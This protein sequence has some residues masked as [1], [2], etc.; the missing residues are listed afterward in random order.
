MFSSMPPAP[1]PPQNIAEKNALLAWISGV[2]LVYG[3]WK[4][5]KRLYK[6]VETAFVNGAA[7]GAANGERDSE[8]FAALIARLDLAPLGQEKIK[9]E[10]PPIVRGGF[11]AIEIQNNY[12][13]AIQN[14][15]NLVVFDLSA[16][17]EPR[18][19]FRWA[20]PVEANV[21]GSRLWIDGNRLIYGNAQLLRVFDLQNPRAPRWVFECAPG[22]ANALGVVG[23]LIFASDYQN[24]RVLNLPKAGENALSE[25][26]GVAV[27]YAYNLA[28][29]TGLVAVS[30]YGNRAYKISFFDVS[31]PN[32]PLQVS[33]IN[34]QNP[35]GW[36]FWGDILVRIDGENLIFTDCS[37]PKN[38][39]EISK[40]KVQGARKF[41]IAGERIFV[42]CQIWNSD[43]NYRTEYKLRILD[44]SQTHSPRLI[45]EFETPVSEMTSRDNLL[46]IAA[47][48]GI[49]ILDVA[50]S[51]RPQPVGQKPSDA[52]FGYL[53]RR[54]R[55][56][57][58]VLAEADGSAFI[59][60]SKAV[61]EA[62]G[63]GRDALDLKAQW[64]SSELVIGGGARWHQSSHGR[65]AY[66][67]DPQ[68]INI[69]VRE[70]R[71]PQLWD[72][73]LESARALWSHP[74]L[75][76]QTSE[77]ARK[78]LLGNRQ[79]VSAPTSAQLGRFLWA[80]SPAF[81][82]FAAREA[83]NRLGEL[84]ARA[85]APLLWIQNAARRR[86]TLAFIEANSG[87]KTEIATHLATLLGQNARDG[88]SRRGRGIALILAARFDLSDQNFSSDGAFPIIPA[89]I[90]SAEAPLRA[91]G[92][93]FCR[94]LSAP[95]TLDALNWLL[96]IP[97]NQR[98][99]FI[100]SLCE[101]ASRGALEQEKIDK[102][103]RHAQSEVRDAAWRLIAASQ[104]PNEILRAVWTKLFG[105]LRRES[106]YSG[107]RYR[108]QYLGEEWRESTP[109]QSA[110][111]SDAALSVLGRCEL[112]SSE[113]LPR[114]GAHCYTGNERNRISPAMWGAFSL[115]LP[116]SQ[117]VEVVVL[118][119]EWTAWRDAWVRA[120][121]PQKIKLAAFWNAVQEFLSGD[122]PEDQKQILRSR[123]FEQSAVAATFGGAAS[124]L[125]PALLM[126]LI[127]AVPDFLWNTW[128]PSL[129]ETLQNDAATREAF[130]SAAR[131][132]PSLEGGFLRAR[133]LEDAEF[134]ATF[135]LLE[136]DALSA[137]NPAFTPLLLAWLRARETTLDRAGWLEAATHP[138]PAV[139]DLGL[140]HLEIIGLDVPGAL[141]LLE[142]RLPPSIAFAQ[143][144]FENRGE[145]L[146]E[147][148]LALSD[149]PQPSVRAFGREFIAA[150]LE[151]LLA[152]GLIGYLQDNPNAE[153][154]SFVAA[155]L[156][157]KPE[158]AAPEF[159]RA[160]LR[161][162]FRARRAKNLIQERRTQSAPLPDDK[163]L[164]EIARGRT[165]CDAEWALSQLARRA[166][167]GAQIEGIEVG[168]TVGI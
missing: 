62:A 20:P 6:E 85:L 119:P 55:R 134:A 130:W 112:P 53:K 46:Y 71:A 33:Q 39:R 91:L 100:E 77:M 76:W 133:L 115:I 153:M 161:S 38:P 75:P 63:Q 144:W 155:Q 98:E 152:N 10:F 99:N 89:L 14:G 140:A 31:N 128:R 90:A 96:Q 126:A 82:N 147:L 8:I 107:D 139:R 154:Q 34:A 87:F 104:T 131:L 27:Q 24:L 79:V 116:A 23:D 28:A 122:K 109:L 32:A 17:L 40:I 121:A 54:A 160:V 74:H 56:F 18:E 58:R 136:T 162:R 148:A 16:P 163:T 150:R 60:L 19:I 67:K 3:P 102:I 78:I 158:L 35:N 48:G 51:A 86:E 135:G 129:L 84:D 43:G 114:F 167:D 159:D 168:E 36:R 146:L 132:S 42:A 25:A 103:V 65:G 68:K 95:R 52:T 57:L 88:L 37:N 44:I 106:I 66:I 5:F 113:V 72:A 105:G 41:H 143:K 2:S 94:R 45:G 73:H 69:K 120:N 149:S 118:T 124:Q 157:E 50:D 93:G 4:N 101:S 111:N 138:L 12:L 30:H 156:L 108:S 29:K 13:Y 97:L 1:F 26:G 127:G 7:N 137:D 151:N 61:L 125:S 21:Y 117:V 164:L 80:D 165:P 9:G 145:K 81:L 70:E 123:T 64:V 49:R 110:I 15:D 166:L 83:Q 22:N 92:F 11:D 59:E 142:S 141:Q 47:P